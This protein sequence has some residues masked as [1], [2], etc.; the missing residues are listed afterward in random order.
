MAFSDQA[1]N[2]KTVYHGSDKIVTE[3]GSSQP[4][5]SVISVSTNGANQVLAATSGKTVRVLSYVI[6]ATTAVAV[7][8]ESSGGTVKS[9]AMPL[10]ANGIISADFTPVG[11]FDTVQ[12]EG[13]TLFLSS[14]VQVSG[15]L[16]Y[17]L[18]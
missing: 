10:G 15:H 3:N 14:G 6:V 18:V 13:L 2:F 4:K 7:T 11:H 16:K 5:D 17:V 1:G 9:G 8:W 12:G